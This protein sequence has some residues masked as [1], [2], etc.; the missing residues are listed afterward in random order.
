MIQECQIGQQTQLLEPGTGDSSV[1]EVQLLQG[2][3]AQETSYACIVD[4]TALQATRLLREAL[5]HRDG[6]PLAVTLFEI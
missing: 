4:L 1:P 2:C 5:L 3:Q 6:L